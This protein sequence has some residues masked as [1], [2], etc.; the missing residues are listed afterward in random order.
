MLFRSYLTFIST[1]ETLYLSYLL[2]STFFISNRLNAFC[3]KLR[4]DDL[5]VT[6]LKPMKQITFCSFCLELAAE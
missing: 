4:V 6:S 3:I 5:A 2:S 1:L